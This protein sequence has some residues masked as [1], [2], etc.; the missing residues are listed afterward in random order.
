MPGLRFLNIREV[1]SVTD[2]ATSSNLVR[3]RDCQCSCRP[4]YPPR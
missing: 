3:L 2:A 1:T 4:N